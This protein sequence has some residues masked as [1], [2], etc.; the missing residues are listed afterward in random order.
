MECG[1]RSLPEKTRKVQTNHGNNFAENPSAS[2]KKRVTAR[3]DSQK[4][5]L[6]PVGI[7]WVFI[8]YVLVLY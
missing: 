8:F 7:G 1:S 3:D 6:N 4:C 5:G 2:K